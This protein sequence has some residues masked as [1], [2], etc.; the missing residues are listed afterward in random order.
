M[1]SDL[2]LLLN[3][4]DGSVILAIDNHPVCRFDNLAALLDWLRKAINWAMELDTTRKA[5]IDF[6][7]RLLEGISLENNG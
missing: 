2:S 6:L 1:P 3:T 7:N 5:E 4:E